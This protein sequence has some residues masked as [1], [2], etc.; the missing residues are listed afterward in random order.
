ML[1]LCCS[2]KDSFSARY[3]IITEIYI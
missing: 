2:E 3:V 1:T